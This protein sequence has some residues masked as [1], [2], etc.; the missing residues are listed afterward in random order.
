MKLNYLVTMLIPAKL[1]PYAKAVLALAGNALAVL[2]VTYAD[3]PRVAAIIAIATALG[4]FTVPNEPKAESDS[5]GLVDL[6]LGIVAGQSGC[7]GCP[8]MNDDS[9]PCAP[10]V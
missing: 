10:R 5:D 8:G 1:R 6:D 3:N 4:V 9:C 2:Q 7:E